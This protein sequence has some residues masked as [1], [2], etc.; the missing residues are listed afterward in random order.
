MV[1]AARSRRALATATESAS[2]RYG[3]VMGSKPAR[4][5]MCVRAARREARE[6]GREAAARKSSR[7]TRNKSSDGPLRRVHE[8]VFAVL[9]LGSEP[10][11]P[12]V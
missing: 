9:A 1:P 11:D 10:I 7:M 6:S 5:E 3:S 2:V 12:R 8:C 4:D